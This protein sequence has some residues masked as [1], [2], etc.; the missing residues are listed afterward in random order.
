MDTSILLDTFLFFKPTLINYMYKD[1]QTGAIMQVE[2]TNIVKMFGTE[3]ELHRLRKL[4]D[5]NGLGFDF[6]T[7][8]RTPDFLVDKPMDEEYNTSEAI[9]RLITFG[10]TDFLEWREFFWGT[11]W[12]N[13]S[14]NWYN[15]SYFKMVTMNTP[16]LGV[17]RRITQLFEIK[18]GVVYAGN[19]EGG[20]FLIEKGTA[21]EE[22]VKDEEFEITKHLIDDPTYDFS[23]WAKL[24][25]KI[26]RSKTLE[27]DFLFNHGS[28]FLDKARQ[29]IDKK[30]ESLVI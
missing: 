2:I 14:T 12:V 28:T 9:N 16:P 29:I 30:G 13:Q 26:G 3:N 15:D 23:R 11:E 17:F 6:D 25:P 21:T 10:A 18:M 5:V 7:I 24:N 8:L 1:P 27:M 19:E 20:L 4:V 22:T